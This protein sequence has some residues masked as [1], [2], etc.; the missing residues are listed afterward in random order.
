ML[1]LWKQAKHGDSME[2][3]KSKLQLEVEKLELLAP[4]ENHSNLDCGLNQTI[5]SMN[6]V[7]SGY[8]EFSPITV[9]SRS[10]PLD[11]DVE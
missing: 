2:N 11:A 5:G 8:G 10:L 3:R 7:L 1:R 4:E 9:R 6:Y